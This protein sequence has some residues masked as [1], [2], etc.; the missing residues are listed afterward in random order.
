MWVLVVVRRDLQ[1][2]GKLI[3]VKNRDSP[4]R[5]VN[6]ARWG[7]LMSVTAMNELRHWGWEF[8]L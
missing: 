8:Q 6:F 4:R 1:L 7:Y 5:R 3:S 2:I